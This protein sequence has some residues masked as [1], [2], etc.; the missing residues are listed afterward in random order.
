MR[1]K[2]EKKPKTFTTDYSNCFCNNTYYT[3]P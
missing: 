2:A 1:V 3:L